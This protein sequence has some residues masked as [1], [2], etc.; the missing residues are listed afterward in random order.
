MIKP[1]AMGWEMY[2]KA[3]SAN[4]VMVGKHE[5]KRLYEGITILKWISKNY[6]GVDWIQLA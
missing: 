1:R 6:E 5:E 3:R 2:E 4:K